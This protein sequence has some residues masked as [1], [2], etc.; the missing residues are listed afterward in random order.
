MILEKVSV[1]TTVLQSLVII[2][3]VFTQFKIVF[4]C[5]VILSDFLTASVFTGVLNDAV[6]KRKRRQS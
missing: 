4:L 1:M 2:A 5:D 6:Q 3:L